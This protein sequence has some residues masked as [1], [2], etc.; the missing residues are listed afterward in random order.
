M[1]N[2]ACLSVIRPTLILSS[3][4]SLALVGCTV[5]DLPNGGVA[6]NPV[7][8]NQLFATGSAPAAPSVP[9]PAD[10]RA[11]YGA[12]DAT[13]VARGAGFP[14]RYHASAFY[15]GSLE[16][17]AGSLTLTYE[18]R[19]A[20]RADISVQSLA[21]GAG[22]VSGIAY[23]RGADLYMT[24]GSTGSSLSAPETCDL[25]LVPEPRGVGIIEQDCTYFHGAA[26]SF[27]GVLHRAGN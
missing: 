2:R 23:R 18:G 9:P 6:L 14:R 5:Q 22:A 24:Q 19:G 8:M 15:T 1:H 21:N 3:L 26:V 10:S 12:T 13:L 25:K 17:G 16:G 11:E 4:A 20:Y 7:P 27:N